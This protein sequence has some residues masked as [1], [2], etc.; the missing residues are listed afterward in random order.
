MSEYIPDAYI[1]PTQGN[2]RRMSIVAV[3]LVALCGVLLGWFLIIAL[4]RG[5][6]PL[7]S[8]DEQLSNLKKIDESVPD[9]VVPPA[10][11]YQQNLEEID[12][13]QTV[14]GSGMTEREMLNNL[15]KIS[16]E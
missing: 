4:S 13:K 10:E 5:D 15:N 1:P 7:D 9:K 2:R 11:G 3:L 14:V 12:T 8:Q 16:P 6:L